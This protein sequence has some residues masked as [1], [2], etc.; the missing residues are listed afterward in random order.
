LGPSAYVRFERCVVVH[1][2]DGKIGRG[3]VYLCWRGGPPTHYPLWPSDEPM[4]IPVKRFLAEYE[5]EYEQCEL[6]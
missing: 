6:F 4:A 3:S 1:N 2:R 5:P